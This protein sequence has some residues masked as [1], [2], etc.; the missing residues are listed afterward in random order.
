MDGE[1]DQTLK[2]L[3][4]LTETNLSKSFEHLNDFCTSSINHAHNCDINLA[5]K[6]IAFAEMAAHRLREDADRS[7]FDRKITLNEYEEISN[8]STSLIFE[9]LSQE[10]ANSIVY[11][12]GCV[13]GG[14]LSGN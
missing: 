9:K 5:L 7:Y 4:E 2:R 13:K 3:K 8:L 10:V 6:D 1:M 12:C 11:S 14:S